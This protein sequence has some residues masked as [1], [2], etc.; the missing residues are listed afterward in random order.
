[1]SPKEHF[2]HYMLL[3]ITVALG[4]LG[5]IVFKN[6]SNGRFLSI[7]ISVLGYVAWGT[8]HHWVEKRLSWAVLSEYFLVAL[9]VIA[10]A[11]LILFSR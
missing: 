5:V 8:W 10:S 2:W 11:S 3:L 4:L 6:S 1:M 9:V 7:F